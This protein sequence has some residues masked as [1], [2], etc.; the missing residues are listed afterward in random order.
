MADFLKC[1][2]VCLQF[3]GVSS[4]DE[5]V[6]SEGAKFGITVQM[7]RD[8]CDI[9]LTDR[10]G[11]GKLTLDD[12]KELTFE[13]AIKVFKKLYWDCWSLDSFP[14]TQKALLVFDAALNHG[15][16]VGAKIVQKALLKMGYN[17]V[18]ADG[19]FGPQTRKALL[20]ASTEQFV[21][22]YFDT[23]LD[24]FNALITAYSRMKEH[25][26]AWLERLDA[27]KLSLNS[28]CDG[29]SCIP[30]CEP[31]DEDES[32][33]DDEDCRRDRRDRRPRR[34]HGGDDG[35]EDE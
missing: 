24:Y 5:S 26:P 20:D 1:A 16:K 19:V 28:I 11:D 29:D 31:A 13:D 35:G 10:D 22:V 33:K 25:M 23:R 2:A 7:L 21:D 14:D 17:A 9:D 6:S 4:T 15:L 30:E 3:E 8:A 27:L 34:R 18:V 12:V 32:G